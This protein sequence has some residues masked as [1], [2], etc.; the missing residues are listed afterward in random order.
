MSHW[1]QFF[2]RGI[3]LLHREAWQ[4]SLP[5]GLVSWRYLWPG[6]NEQVRQHRQLWWHSNA[7]WPR[8]LWCG[9]EF[10][11]WLRW[12]TWRGPR[13]TWSVV[14][15]NQLSHPNGLNLWQNYL[16]ALKLTLGWCI[17]P[18][19][20]AMF[21]LNQQPE[22]AL[23]YVY[24][25]ETP[26]YH[27]L[28][29]QALGVR[30]E[31][32]RCIQNKVALAELLA[33]AG[34]PM[35]PTVQCA[36]ASSHMAWAAAVGSQTQVFCKMR[37]GNQGRGAFAA[38][39]GADGWQGQTFTGQP[40]P[41]TQTVHDAWLN[42]LTLGDALVH[43]LLRNHPALASLAH[44][45]RETITLRL[46]TEWRQG[47]VTPLW[48]TL[49]VPLGLS[50]F[51]RTRYGL[52]AIDVQTGVLQYQVMPLTVSAPADHAIQALLAQPEQ[53]RTVPHWLGL[54]AASLT[55]HALFPD[56]KAIAWD[57][58]ITPECPLLLEGNTG[59]GTATPQILN[60]GLLIS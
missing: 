42:L 17:A 12:V 54:C 33:T 29:N 34:V 46:I 2:L 10:W 1:I 32:L 55:A 38:W 27:H 40:L 14:K 37:S 25:Q 24:S 60:K 57:W 39:Q 49:E 4:R 36:A 50:T 31:S 26:A 15:Q 8:L 19:E 53:Q 59:W 21:G 30:P 22:R 43:P 45:G 11:L 51:G 58:V 7:R 48:P 28:R 20:L 3:K 13:A 56:V 44:D 16:Q 23:N 35:V 5:H 9:L 6:G 41:D 18:R 47:V 52:V